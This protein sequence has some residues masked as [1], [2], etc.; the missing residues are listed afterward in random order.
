MHKGNRLLTPLVLVVSAAAVLGG[1][2][3]QTSWTGGSGIPG[4]VTEWGE[5][6]FES[7]FIDCTILP[8]CLTLVET[9]AMFPVS[10]DFDGARL[11]RSVDVDGDGDFDVIGGSAR[12]ADYLVWW[13]NTD[14]TATAWDYHVIDSTND[15]VNAFHPVDL[16]GDGDQDIIACCSTSLNAYLRWLENDD[17][18][19]TSW[20]S[21][22]VDNSF[23]GC[24]SVSAADIDGD[25]DV[26]LL[27]SN[28][29]TDEIIWWENDDG[30][31]SSLTE[32]VV[33][34]SFDG[35]WTIYAGDIDGD[36]DTDVLGAAKYAGDITWWENMDGS[37]TSWTARVI[38]EEFDRA[39]VV[40]AADID[41]DRDLDILGSSD[42]DQL[43]VL[44]ENVDGSGASWDKRTIASG[45][46]A[47]S[48]CVD[49]INND[50]YL[51]V[52]ASGYQS[53]QIIWWENIDGTG[54]TWSPHTVTGSFAGA[55]DA[56]AVDIDL[57]ENMDIIGAAYTAGQ[58]CW[59]GSSEYAKAGQL[60]SSIL[61]I[62]DRPD[63]GEISW[64][65]VVPAGTSISM[66][67]RASEDHTAMGSWSNPITQ[68]GS[69]EEIL[70]DGTRYVQYR[71]LLQTTDPDST[72]V[73][74]QV[75][76]VWEP[77]G[78]GEG[79]VPSE[80]GLLPFSPN[81][82]SAPVARLSM[83]EPAAVELSVFD[84]T[85]RLVWSWQDEGLQAGIHTV[86]LAGLG[87]GVYICRF[88]TAS[89]TSTER[90]VVLR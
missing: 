30:S 11:V 42:A 46:L 60:E 17:G 25:G 68:P 31:A 21:H 23:N 86:D 9:A 40:T 16:D 22:T 45:V 75:V 70:R 6:F 83:P 29:K 1:T 8:G 44:W 20:T 52:V 34:D 10:S 28:S 35:A 55:S 53:G 15:G 14:G 54:H 76:L 88:A 27:A 79:E 7:N 66:Q 47:Y 78:T 71:A 19:G 49:D 18:T 5:E 41:R 63:W 80:F 56:F 85:G 89:D 32:H 82:A 37:G 3:Y 58:V 33:T 39:R 64:N 48:I 72:P 4:P 73:L 43:I 24:M 87:P 50:H 81:P 65:A 13:E 84:L 67:V 38:E 90:L 62:R 2:A 57:D 26:D 74:M 69:L 59:W 61:D 51:D 77:Q 12:D 36:G